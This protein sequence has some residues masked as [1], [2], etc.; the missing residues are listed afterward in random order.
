MAE[1]VPAPFADLVARLC[2]EPQLQDSL[3]ELP[4]RKWYLPSAADPDLSVW[5]HHAR[6]GNPVGPAAGPH[7][8][9][10]QNLLLSY[11]AGSRVLELKTVQIDDRLTIP[12]PCI[13]MTNVGY[14][15]EWSQE[16]L[17][18]DSVREYVAGA[19]LIEMFRRSESLTGGRLDGGAGD[20]V[21][22]LSVGYDLA[23]I[24]SGKVC[25]FLDEMRNAGKWVDHFRTEI[26]KSFRGLRD[27]DFVT[28]LSTSITLSTFHGC[29]ADEIERITE[30]LIGEMGFDVIVKMNPP[31][32]GRERL[33]QLLYDVMGYHEVRV[34]PKAYEAV[35]SFEDSIELCRR[36]TDFANQRNRKLGFKFS[37]TLEVLNHLDFFTADNEIMYLSAQPLHVITMALTD[38]FRRSVGP[39]V[40]ISF[41]AGID[42]RN[43]PLAVACGFV[44]VT[45]CSDLL[46]PG[47][48]GRL[49][50]YLSRL[51]EDMNKIG[52]ATIDEFVLRRFNHQAEAEERFE[53]E[54]GTTVLHWASLLNTATAALMARED[55][56]YY[57]EKNGRTPRRIDS[58]LD[59]FDC[60]S[61]D[62]CLPVCP[63]AANF[64]YPA[65]LVS[66]DYQDFDV[67]PDGSFSTAGTKHFE[68]DE[69][70]QIACYADFC[71]E[72][73][74]CDTFCPEYGGPYIEKPSFFGSRDSWERAT[75]RDGFFVT[76][77]S[78]GLLIAGRIKQKEYE[79]HWKPAKDAY[80]LKDGR[81]SLTIQST[82]H[83]VASA[84]SHG[85]GSGPHRVDM[86]I[87]HILRHLLHGIL[88]K[89]RINQVN[90][91]WIQGP[92]P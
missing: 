58:H 4:R 76:S 31:T 29:P 32:I 92:Q 43:F 70:H 47:G 67:Q 13:D 10:A 41:S 17:V 19:M 27:L 51:C 38:A 73:G 65:P 20:W 75:P 28:C 66:F 49:P 53:Q 59:L 45:V 85:A 25:R 34:N 84:A 48:Y 46:R 71:N 68:I 79:L 91:A 33:E 23:G 78:D 57:A 18:D 21:F 1:L 54:S 30:F 11:V 35:V 77:E 60:I 16:L 8:Q 37:N 36:L 82:D 88:D 80:V 42:Q 26:P 69:H 81:V 9:M 5:F 87:Y 50:A 63:N 6:V 3:F 56:R 89:S 90:A 22:D 39:S 72:C 40:P 24:T 52:A 44:P 12:R 62:K 61:C 64:I 74:N 2:L 14:N 83:R 55:Q 7:T 15:V 86:G